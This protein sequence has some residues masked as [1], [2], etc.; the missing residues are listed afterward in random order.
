MAMTKILG[1]VKRTSLF[2]AQKSITALVRDETSRSG[3]SVIQLYYIRNK[4]EC[5]YLTTL[6]SLV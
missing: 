6:S 5:L 2:P 4:L 1:A 3:P